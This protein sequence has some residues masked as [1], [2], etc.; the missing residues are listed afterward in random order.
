MLNDLLSG[1]KD[2][3]WNYMYTVH[4]KTLKSYT[5]ATDGHDPFIYDTDLGRYVPGD[6]KLRRILA[7]SMKHEWSPARVNHIFTWYK[8]RS[9]RLWEA[10]PLDR[11][12]VLNGILDLETRRIEPHSP[13]FLSPVQ[14]NAAW[15]PEAECPFI[16]QFVQ[17]VFPDDSD[18]IFYQLAGLFL[19]PD[20]RFRK[21]VL[22]LGTSATGKSLALTLLRQ[23]LQPRNVSNVPL[24]DLTAGS[25]DLA[26]LRG[27]LLNI[28]AD[29][30][31]R[32]FND[33]ATFKQIVDGRLA[34]IRAPRKL[35]DSI[36]F[37]PFTRLIAS[38][39]RVPRSADNSLGYLRRWLVVPFDTEFKDRDFDHSLLDMIT[40]PQEL[41]GLLNRAVEGY[42][43]VLS[44]NAIRQGARI[45]EANEQFLLDSDSTRIFFD[46]RVQECSLS[47]HVDRT[48]LYGAYKSWC[49]VHR[50]RPATAH[51]FYNSV[52][53]VFRIETFMTT[54]RRLFKGIRLLG[55]TTQDGGS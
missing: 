3:P 31:D 1:F 44:G 2:E 50:F 13:D 14:I 10:P 33:T 51:Q 11:V 37:R 52:W 32:D 17:Q 36:E 40:T 16:D 47:E 39:N 49:D 18:D 20:S 8:D 15:D 46:E 29:V 28:S 22:F 45:N 55:E 54:G 5:F 26:E 34:V 9:R 24:H 43:T 7:D 19:T 6:D 48:E 4:S 23:F 42:H 41:S 27:K 12:N 30:P 21:A 25:F 38:T 35:R 53:D